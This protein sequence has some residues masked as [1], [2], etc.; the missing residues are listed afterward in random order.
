MA[1]KL[2]IL[3]DWWSNRTISIGGLT[4]APPSLSQGASAGSAEAPFVQL[5]DLL[6]AEGEPASLPA[7]VEV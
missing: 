2:L 3:L 6:V 7:E 4:D 1:Q 5:L